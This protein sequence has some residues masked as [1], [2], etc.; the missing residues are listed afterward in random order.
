MNVI[1]P[2]V[3][4]VEA[5]W[6]SVLLIRVSACK[7]IINQISG[8]LTGMLNNTNLIK[9]SLMTVALYYDV[10]FDDLVRFLERKKNES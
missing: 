3:I 8:Y 7:K 1:G 5:I 9:E 10:D 2:I 6:I 4:I